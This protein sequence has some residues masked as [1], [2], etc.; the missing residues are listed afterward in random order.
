[1]T[2]QT[3]AL[4]VVNCGQLVTL[5]GPSRPRVGKELS[6]LSII[7]DG[8]ML[9]LDGEIEWVGR[10]QELKNERL[11]GRVVADADG[12]VVLPELPGIG[13]EGKAALAQVLE[14]VAA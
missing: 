8:A 10:A 13:F 4:A 14:E 3:K 5:A 7:N 9:A 12:R 11:A 1:M 6:N 2:L